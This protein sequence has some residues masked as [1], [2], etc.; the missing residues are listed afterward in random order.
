MF[1]HSVFPTTPEYT[2]MM[3]RP[4]LSYLSLDLQHS[5]Q[6]PVYNKHSEGSELNKKDSQIHIDFSVILDICDFSF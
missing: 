6:Y 3:I 4:H 5:L 2:S 1:I